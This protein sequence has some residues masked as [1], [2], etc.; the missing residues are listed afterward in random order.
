MSGQQ[1]SVAV[2][3]ALLGAGLL[4]LA[5]MPS[6]V[7]AAE[8]VAEEVVVTGSRVRGV[9]PV[10][11]AVTTVG[12]E[13]IDR[14]GQISTD[15]IL[16]ELPQNFD[17]GVSE[18]SRGQSGGAGNVVYGNTV[19]LRGIGPSATLV[20]VD[21]HRVVNNSRSTDPSII[22]TLGLERVEVVADGASAVY[23]SDAIAGVVNL[24]PRR[25]LD[26]IEAFGR[27]G[28]ADGNYSES[29]VGGAIGRVFDRGQFML[30][31][32]HANRDA[33]SGD[34]RDFFRSDQTAAGGRDYRITRCNPGTLKIGA[35][36][37]AIPAGGLTD[38][39]V[40]SLV[41]GTSNKCDELVGQDL[42][43]EQTYD[44]LNATASYEFNDHVEFVF[45]GF[46]S[47]REFSRLP[48]YGTATLTVPQ[49]NAWFVR[50][51]GF[52]GTS[53]SIDY[54]FIK[55]FARNASI[56]F[57]ENWQVSPA[58]RVKLPASWQFEAVASYGENSDTSD[59]LLGVSNGALNAALASSDPTKAFDP[60]G[61]GRT[62][63]AVRDGI[64]NQIEGGMV[65]ATSWTLLEEGRW[66][67][68]RMV[69]ED[70]AS[71]PILDFS[72]TPP[73]ESVLIDRPDLPSLGVG[74]GSQAPTGAAIANAILDAVGRHV[75][76]IPFTPARVLAALRG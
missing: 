22:P 20:I 47:R 15:R 31:Y 6:W 75:P 57:A 67:A 16:K 7:A 35:V 38:A 52:A 71:Y 62:T 50:P 46:F 17:L 72:Q 32:E 18:N 25:S 39:N 70:Y 56:G 11:S 14:A 66:N 51:T 61:L 28:I 49:T 29:V 2:R 43:P 3:R 74:E 44:S 63:Q 27:H 58:L 68:G 64:A 10:G 19:N 33:L 5:G 69:S 30:A 23:G 37:Y 55:D 36:S 59:S 40:G 4:A 9:Q 65:Q 1:V 21:G 54:S 34:D 13:E 42:S 12:R 60:Y 48:G 24:I 45:D 73:I 26:G 76:E 41:A 53:Y 8:E